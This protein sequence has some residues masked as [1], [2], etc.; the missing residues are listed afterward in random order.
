ME[1]YGLFRPER[2]D[3]DRGRITPKVMHDRMVEVYLP[4]TLSRKT[5][6]THDRFG[7]NRPDRRERRDEPSKMSPS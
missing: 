3:R 2:G 1:G 4:L 7:A 6:C 5:S